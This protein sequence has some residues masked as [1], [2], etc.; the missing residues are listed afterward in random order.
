LVASTSPEEHAFTDVFT[1]VRALSGEPEARGDDNALSNLVLLDMGTN[2]SY[3]NA[4]FPVKRTR[5]IGLDKQGQFVPPATRN[6][7]LKY[8][9]EQAAQ[10]MLWDNAD[11]VAYGAA[12]EGTLVRFFTPLLPNG[13]NA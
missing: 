7:F 13:G 10:L 3:K 4:I 2:R 9:S 6:V 1:R 8:F 5:I 11:Q 12:I